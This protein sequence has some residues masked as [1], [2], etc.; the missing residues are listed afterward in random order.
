M[1]IWTKP[2]TPAGS[3]AFAFL[4]F[5]TATPTKMSVVLSDFGL[6][7][8]SGYNVTEVFDGIHMGLLKPSDRLT[9]E[10]NPSGVFFAK[11]VIVTGSV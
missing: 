11:A 5:G 6:H 9:V 3:F 10:V 1:E 2:I 4:N 7:N 8:L